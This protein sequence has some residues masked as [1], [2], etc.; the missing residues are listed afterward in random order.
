M[1]AF[2]LRFLFSPDF[3][4]ALGP[5]CSGPSAGLMSARSVSAWIQASPCVGKLRTP[6][7]LLFGF[8]AEGEG[9]CKCCRCKRPAMGNMSPL[10]GSNPRPYAY[11]AHALP[12]ELK[13]PWISTHT[14]LIR[15][16]APTRPTRK[17]CL[18]CETCGGLRGWARTAERRRGRWGGGIPSPPPRAG[19]GRDFRR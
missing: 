12:A 9:A 4:C 14:R 17:G 15:P 11:E 2:S 1:L 7:A 5:A 10:W 19:A 16:P 13:R 8:G 18:S 3:R 6:W